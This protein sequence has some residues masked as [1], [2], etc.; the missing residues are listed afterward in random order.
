MSNGA[1]AIRG[2]ALDAEVPV[3]FL[4][5]ERKLGAVVNL[6]VK[7]AAAGPVTVRLEPCGSARAW[8]VDPDGK[9]V[10]KPVPKLVIAMVVTPG[11]ASRSLPSDKGTS[12]LS[13]DEGGLTVID[14]INYDTALAPDALGRIALP[15]LIPGATY[16]FI[17]YTTV[18]R[19]QTG[20]EI[21]KEFTIKPGQKLNLGDIRVAKPP[22]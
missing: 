13:A 18:V 12:L 6:S 7:S 20:P 16:R 9:P 19:G 3:Y 8:L 10:A 2:L 21:R 22:S 1:F 14:P 17:D 11:P 4:E 5:P 15:V